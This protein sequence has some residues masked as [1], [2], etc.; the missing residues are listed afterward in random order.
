[1]PDKIAAIRPLIYRAYKLSS[2]IDIFNDAYK[3][4]QYF[5]ISNGFNF[6]F[7]DKIKQKV[8]TSIRNTQ[9]NSTQDNETQ[10]IYI[11]LN[12]NKANEHAD[13]K[14]INRVNYQQ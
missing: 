8:L 14:M 9:K 10:T 4:I 6:K 13:I 11:K 5:F 12:Y 7:I 1:M 2:N 3:I